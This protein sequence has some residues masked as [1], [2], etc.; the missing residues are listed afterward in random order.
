MITLSDDIKIQLHIDCMSLFCGSLQQLW[1]ILTNAAQPLS[2]VFI[3]G[4]YCGMNKLPSL[5]DYLADSIDGLRML[6]TRRAMQLFTVTLSSMNAD[7]PAKA[8]IK[9]IKPFSG[10]YS[11]PR[12]AV[13]GCSIR[14]HL[15]FL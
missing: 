5:E 8:V 1:P 9:P 14:E 4:H 7:V 6:L 11:C 13:R 10:Y 15:V 12:C 2:K 3:V